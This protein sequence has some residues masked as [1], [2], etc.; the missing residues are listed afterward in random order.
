MTEDYFISYRTLDSLLDMREGWNYGKGG[1]I[2]SEVHRAAKDIVD[3]ALNLGFVKV[4]SFP[5]ASRSAI[6]SFWTEHNNFWYKV[7]PDLTCEQ[8]EINEQFDKFPLEELY[9]ILK[10]L[11]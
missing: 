1:P 9:Q 2:S 11:V 6:L 4:I 7:N 10:R 8:H 5:E 3:F